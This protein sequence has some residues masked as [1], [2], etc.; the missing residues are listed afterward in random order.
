VERDIP[1]KTSLE[2]AKIRRTC[3]LIES[4][5]IELRDY[6]RA[7]VTTQELNRQSAE[8]LHAGGAGIALKGYRG[9][10]AAICTSVNNVAAHGVPG[11]FPLQ[12][13][14][15]ISVDISAEIE[16][17]HGDGAWTYVVGDSRPDT[18]LIVR[19]AWQATLA[20]VRAARAGGRLG[21]VGAAVH[22]V[23]ARAGC[24]VLDNFVGHGIGKGMHEEPM[25]LNFGTEGTGRPIVPGMVVTIEPILC[26]GK[27]EVNVLADGW[28]IVTSDGSLCAQF[29]HTIAVFG[30]RTEVLTLSAPRSLREEGPIF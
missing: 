29:E 2:I 9:F 11:P 27:P 17:W 3:R 16:G 8:L 6:V 14:D 19:T 13:Q 25:V 30:D 12:N 20:G 10:P 28:S 15:I 23:A 21:D 24:S 5:F 22:E 7:G 26:L 1:L 4:V 18:R